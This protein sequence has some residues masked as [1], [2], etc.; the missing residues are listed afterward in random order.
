MQQSVRLIKTLL[1]VYYAYMI[2]YRAELFLW[3]LSNSLPLIFLGIW[4]EASETGNFALNSVEFT[5]YF[6]AVFLIR[7][8]NVVWVIWDFEK[9]VVDVTVYHAKHFSKAF[10]I[11]AKEVINNNY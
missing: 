8:F 5:R 11:N 6:I 10:I 7:Q 3:A 2:E 4:F 9:Q 1:T